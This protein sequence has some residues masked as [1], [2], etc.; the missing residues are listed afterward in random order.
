MRKPII[1]IK[2]TVRLYSKLVDLGT[3][4]ISFMTTN[5]NFAT[6]SPTLADVQTTVDDVVA[7]IAKWGPKKNRGSHADLVDLQLKARILSDM[8]KAEAQYVQIT[9]QAAASTDYIA[10]GNI[11]TSSGFALASIG[12]PQGI[13]Q[14]VQSFHQFISRELNRNQVKLRWKKPLNVANVGNV[15]QYRVLRSNS[16]DFTTA[17]QVASVTKSTFTDVNTASDAVAWTYWVIPCNGA[18]S[19]VVSDPV[20][21]AVLGI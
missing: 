2:L 17:V 18:G 3:R 7:A 11:I 13:L 12:S 8:L 16:T 20:T 4:V 21:I 15:K 5:P 9:A 10:Q 6:P 14:K 19:G 1:S